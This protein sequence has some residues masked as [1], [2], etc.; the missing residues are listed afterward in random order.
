MREF[1]LFSCNSSVQCRPQL[2]H[3]DFIGQVQDDHIKGF[4]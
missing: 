2:I 1:W 4:L 3:A